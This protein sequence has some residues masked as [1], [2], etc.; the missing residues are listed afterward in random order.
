MDQYPSISPNILKNSSMNCSMTGL[1]IYLIILHVRK[2]FEDASC[3]K[4]GFIC[5]S[6]SEFW[7]CLD[8]AR[9]ATIMPQYALIPL[10]MPEHGWI[11]LNVPKYVWKCL[12]K[13]LWFSTCLII[14]CISHGFE[15]VS[16][17]KY[18]KVL[19]ML[20]YSYN[21]IITIT[22]VVMLECLSARFVHPGPLLLTILSF[23]N[24]S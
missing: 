15:Y 12:N 13:L 3:S 4:Y 21:N 24:T 17:I 16:V 10:S 22:S 8:I 9:Y 20:R 23:S 5:N 6:Y 18:A 14:T 19:N 11:L 1:W 7:I 2:A